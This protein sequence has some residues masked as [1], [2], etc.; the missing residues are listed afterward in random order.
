MTEL[1]I[2]NNSNIV[3]SRNKFIFGH[4]HPIFLQLSV[5]TE[6]VRRG[7]KTPR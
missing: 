4:E 3:D 7:E 2:T 1:L 6:K 5:N